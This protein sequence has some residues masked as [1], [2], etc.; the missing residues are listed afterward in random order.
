MKETETDCTQ[1]TLEMMT[2]FRN[3]SMEEHQQR[4]RVYCRII[5]MEN[6]KDEF[7]VLSI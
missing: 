5:F 1:L 4:R 3:Q 2:T 6:I 7:Y